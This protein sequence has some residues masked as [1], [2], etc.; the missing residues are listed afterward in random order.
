[1]AKPKTIWLA[2]NDFGESNY[3][4]FSEEP[5]MNGYGCF[6]SAS[7]GSDFHIASMCKNKFES[8]TDLTLKPGEH[9]QIEA[10]IKLCVTEPE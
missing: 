2:R 8:I 3:T 7:K 6:L 10:P 4:L 9:I 5:R 1:M